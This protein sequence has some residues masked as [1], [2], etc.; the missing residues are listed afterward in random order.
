[1][2]LNFLAIPSLFISSFFFFLLWDFTTYSM[3]FDFRA[4][5]SWL[6]IWITYFP[7]IS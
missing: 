6:F 7:I 5:K 4:P 3:T 2:S 1:L